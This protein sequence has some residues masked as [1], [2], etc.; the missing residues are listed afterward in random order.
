MLDRHGLE[1]ERME[2]NV[3]GAPFTTESARM[4][5]VTRRR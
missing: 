2:G 5:V 3:E 4:L 1:I